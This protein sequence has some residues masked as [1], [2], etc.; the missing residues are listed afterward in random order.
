MAKFVIRGTTQIT[1]FT[2][3]FCRKLRGKCRVNESNQRTMAIFEHV[4]K[5]SNNHSFQVVCRR[6]SVNAHVELRGAGVKI[7]QVHLLPGKR[8]LLWAMDHK[9]AVERLIPG[10]L[11]H[12]GGRVHK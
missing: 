6:T 7:G 3:V 1:A 10:V 2:K 4:E 8:R 9:T 5:C 12:A 11:W